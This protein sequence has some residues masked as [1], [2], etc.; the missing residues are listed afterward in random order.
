MFVPNR[1][2]ISYWIVCICLLACKVQAQPKNS[3]LLNSAAFIH[4][5][6]TLGNAHY[7]L[8]QEQK[9]TVAFLGGS[10]THMTAGNGESWRE[11]L[12]AYL[13]QTYPGVQ[14]T[15]IN[16]GIPSLGSLPHAFRLQQDVLD[17]GR[18]DLL[19]V[20]SAVNDHVNGTPALVQRRALEG[21]VRHALRAN[22]YM[23]I[24]LMAFVDEDKMA[25]YRAGRV[26]AEIQVHQAIAQKYHLPFINLAEEVTRRIDQGEFDWKNDFKDLHPS[27]FGHGIYFN[28]IK[29]LLA[30]DFAGPAPAHLVKQQLPAAADV[31]CYAHGA[32]AALTGAVK[33]TGFVFDSSWQ[34]ADAAG[35]REGFV[36]VPAWTAEQP[37]ASLDWRFKGT[38]AGIAVVSGPDAGILEYRIDNGETKTVDLF[39]QW[40]SGLHLPWYLLLGDGLS[41]RQHVLHLRVSSTHNKGSKGTAC[42]IVHFLVNR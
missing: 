31:F 41:N 11:R 34:P 29:T 8:A 27:P 33:T 17:K 28:T 12:G 20:E 18:I 32:Y 3:A 19:F 5:Y 13:Q 38:A 36:H 16:A 7:R 6:G 22:P 2:K 14:L 21:I 15:L 30:K 24:V 35:T 39:T 42:R 9:M 37:G 26:P 10:I 25:D 23:N 40:S 4:E 1:K